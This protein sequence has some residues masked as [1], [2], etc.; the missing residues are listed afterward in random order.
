ML[1]EKSGQTS[2]R[3]VIR[4]RILDAAEDIFAE[5]GFKGACLREIATRAECNVALLGYYF[6]NKEGLY[7]SVLVRHFRRTNLSGQAHPVT[8]RFPNPQMNSLYESIYA[9]A[10]ICL[11]NTRIQKI[12]M[13]EMMKGGDRA[14][15]A[16]KKVE[17]GFTG[18]L[19]QILKTLIA[20][21][22]VRPELDVDVAV[23]SLIG[24]IIYSAVATPMLKALYRFPE[25]GEDYVDALAYHLTQ[26]FFKGWA[27]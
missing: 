7:E 19:Q 2:E 18:R 26:T 17:P 25:L 16:F 27:L 6:E 10:Q 9:F 3:P 21:G 14:V 23:I 15:S 5:Q 1:T 12:L 20:N 11:Q 8:A 13:Q 24:P 22:T 4:D